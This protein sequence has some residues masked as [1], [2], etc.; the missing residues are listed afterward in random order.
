MTERST[1]IHLSGLFL[2]A[3]RAPLMMPLRFQLRKTQG[4]LLKSCDT[5]RVFRSFDGVNRS[6][7]SSVD[8]RSRCCINEHEALSHHV[9][10]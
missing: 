7:E 4:K 6:S 1:S 2:V 9:H 8:Q 3:I 5:N 10:S